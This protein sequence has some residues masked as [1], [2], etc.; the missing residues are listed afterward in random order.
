MRVKH[1]GLRQVFKIVEWRNGCV[2]KTKQIGYAW[3]TLPIDSRHLDTQSEDKN[4]QYHSISTDMMQKLN[5]KTNRT[6]SDD[7]PDIVPVSISKGLIISE[8]SN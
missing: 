1:Q 3:V 5:W 6:V 8:A 2:Y 4:I 7:T